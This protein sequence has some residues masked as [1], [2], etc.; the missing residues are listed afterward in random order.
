MCFNRLEL[1]GGDNL[2][3]EMEGAIREA[4]VHI[5]VFSP[6]FA[7]SSLCLNELMLR[8]ESMKDTESNSTI[9]PVFYASQLLWTGENNGVY[10]QSLFN[11]EEEENFKHRNY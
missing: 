11:F 7:N 8:L 6:G 2:T 3:P 1:Q 9:I 5:A 10:S 4:S